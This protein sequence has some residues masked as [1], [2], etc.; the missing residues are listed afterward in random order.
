[1]SGMLVLVLFV[2]TPKMATCL[3]T[4]CS[5]PITTCPHYLVRTR[6]TNVLSLGELAWS[7]TNR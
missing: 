5:T 7:Q 6:A 4:R 3:Y 1:M 2:Y